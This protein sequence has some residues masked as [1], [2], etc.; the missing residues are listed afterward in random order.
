MCQYIVQA[1]WDYDGDDLDGVYTAI[2]SRMGWYASFD[3]TGIYPS[4]RTLAKQTKFSTRTIDR[5]LKYFRENKFL[6]VHLKA[7]KSK[8]RATTYRFNFHRINIPV[9]IGARFPKISLQVVDKSCKTIPPTVT[10]SYGATVT[11]SLTHTTESRTKDHINI[12]NKD[13]MIE[14]EKTGDK[15]DPRVKELC[16]QLTK[17]GI[18]LKDILYWTSV[19][20]LQRVISYWGDLRHQQIEKPSQIK[21]PGAYFRVVMESLI[22]NPL[23]PKH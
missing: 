4:I 12:I 11:Q 15:N 8:H 14:R 5:A 22:A 3:G 13:H 18:N 9:P 1:I 17:E 7:N 23:L 21:N 6:I 2:L 10:Q 20:G 19:L 16:R